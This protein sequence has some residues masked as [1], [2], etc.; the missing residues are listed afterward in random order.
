MRAT[1]KRTSVVS[2]E[3][4]ADAPDDETIARIVDDLGRDR[5]PVLIT[6]RPLARIMPSQ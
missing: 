1:G 4:F 6:L 3:F 2:S 5:V